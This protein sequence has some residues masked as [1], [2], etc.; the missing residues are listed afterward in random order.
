MSRQLRNRLTYDPVSSYTVAEH[1]YVW[2]PPLQ[3]PMP[4]TYK[5]VREAAPYKVGD[6]VYVVHGDGY[7]KAIIAVVDCA[8]DTYD[9]WRECYTVFPETKAGHWSKLYYTAHPGFIQ[10]GYQRAGLAPDIPK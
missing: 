10:R 9:D 7:R 8:K 3:D 6:V 1:R 4:Y 5:E 2:N